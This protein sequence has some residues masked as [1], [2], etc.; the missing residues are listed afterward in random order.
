MKQSYARVIWP[1]HESIR[2][3]KDSELK[4]FRESI[5]KNPRWSR[6]EIFESSDSYLDDEDPIEVIEPK[7]RLDK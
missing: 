2:F 5:A 3:W 7:K 4:K 1:N 6:V